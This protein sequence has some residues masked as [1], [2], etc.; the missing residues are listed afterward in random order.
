MMDIRLKQI[1]QAE[2]ESHIKT[3]RENKLYGNSGWLSKPIQTVLNIIPLFEGYKELRILDLGAGVGRNCIP[4]AMKYRD[5]VCKID[6]VDI[7]EEAIQIL[8][9]NAVVYH[10][11]SSICGVVSSIEDYKIPTNQYDLIMAVSALE[12]IDSKE[13]FQEKLM[14]IRKG[15]CKNGIVC[16]VINSN[17]KEKDRATGEMLSP[18]FEVNPATGELR[19]QLRDL[20]ADWQELKSAVGQQKYDIPRDNRIVELTSDVVTYVA[21]NI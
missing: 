21:R 12:H 10:V 14:E 20:F 18:Q 11:E 15:I 9:D 8:N 17:I 1:R 7:L 6:C 3:Y 4:F 5:I 19:S 2:K 16:L 13:S